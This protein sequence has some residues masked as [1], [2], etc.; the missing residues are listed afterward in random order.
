[1]KTYEQFCEDIKQRESEGNY[2][3][4]N[5]YGF[6]GA[7]QFGKARLCDLGLCTRKDKT[8]TSM[9]NS[10]FMFIPPLSEEI[11]LADKDL[12]D[13]VF[14]KHVKALKAQIIYLS[15]KYNFQVQ[16]C[17][18]ENPYDLSGCV[19]AAHLTGPKSVVDLLTAKMKVIK[20]GFGTDTT[21]YLF[22]FSGYEIP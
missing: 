5:I 4:K 22:K 13:Q 21:E 8:S 19:A 15:E 14:N 11:F 17:Y 16:G 3:C 12:Q 10:S 20:D 2:A 18:K 1:M 7:Y 6:L 9:E